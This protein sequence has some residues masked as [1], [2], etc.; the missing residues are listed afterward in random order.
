MHVITVL[1]LIVVLET[2]ALLRAHH[3]PPQHGWETALTALA[4]AL[5]VS[6]LVMFVVDAQGLAQ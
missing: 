5:L 3:G 1:T 6:T 4:A 2:K